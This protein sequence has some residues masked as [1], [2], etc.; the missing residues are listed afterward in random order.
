MLLLLKSGNPITQ[1]VYIINV[2]P[3]CCTDIDKYVFTE[4]KSGKKLF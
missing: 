1:C 2:F 4:H 3:E